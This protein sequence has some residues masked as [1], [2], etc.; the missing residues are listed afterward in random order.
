MRVLITG[1][2]GFAG[3][4][5]FDYLRTKK[6]I[7]VGGV[8]YHPSHGKA[9]G[10]LLSELKIF[11]GDLNN[12]QFVKRIIRDFKP[13]Y[14][15]HLAAQASAAVS[16]L[17]PE[18]TILGNIRSQLNILESVRNYNLNPKILVVGSA[19]EYGLVDKKDLPIDE[20]TDLRPIQ[21]YAVSKIAQDFLGYQYHLSYGL[22][23]VR[24]RPFNYIGPRQRTDFVV[25]DFSS[26][27]AEI[28]H[29]K[30]EPV[31][32]VGNIEAKRD[33]TDVRDMVEAFYLAIEKGESGEV[34]N[35]GSGQSYSISW[36]LDQL[37]ATG[38]VKIKVEVE[39]KRLR[40]VDIPE[41]ICDNSKFK[42]KTGWKPKIDIQTTLKDT[43]DY[44]LS[45]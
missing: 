41:T 10:E 11:A 35:L 6:D 9:L 30:K 28:I 33:F 7:Q 37:I 39:K 31:V 42:N 4:H 32:R 22:K 14:I 29:G 26:Q 15:Y 12:L 13:D 45:K 24:V 17:D 38:G 3:S 27:V 44:Y 5:L 23:V 25:A 20:E 2:A 40:P 19:E 16:F 34:Y 18:T 1:V 36:V 8:V 43:L 21:P